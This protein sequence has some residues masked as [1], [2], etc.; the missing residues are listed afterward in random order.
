MIS[1]WLEEAKV[2]AVFT[3]AGMSTE[4]GLPDFRSAKSGLWTVKDPSRIAS[5]QALNENVEEFFEFYRSRVSG[6]NE[7]SPNV[8]HHILASWEKQGWVDGIITQNVDGF[9]S[10]AGSLHVMELHGS[11]KK[12]HCQSCGTELDSAEYMKGNYRCKCG[13]TLRP[14]VVLFGE[15]LPELPF[16][17]ALSL[18]ESA[19]L[20]IVLGSS[21][22]VSPA[23][24]F[25]L[26]AK[27]N[28][29]KL[30]IVNMEPTEFDGYADLVI[31]DRKIG[32]V[33]TEID[34]ELQGDR[35]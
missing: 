33:L 34:R 9:H 11:L 17:N 10:A 4:S 24:Q 19:D 8:G 2:T 6:V 13:G 18:S 21:L 5:V 29:A 12:V 22:T 28:G 31:H 25:P 30:V 7:F 27:Q 16:T 35:P 3:G 23:N 32:E 1:K 14:S 26:I 15:M 20:F